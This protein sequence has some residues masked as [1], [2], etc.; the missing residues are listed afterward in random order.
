MWERIWLSLMSSQWK[1]GRLGCGGDIWLQV[2]VQ[3][4]CPEP[5]QLPW[6]VWKC[7]CRYDWEVPICLNTWADAFN[8][9]GYLGGDNVLSTQ[10]STLANVHLVILLLLFLK[11]F[12]IIWVIKVILKSYNS[13]TRKTTENL[14][15]GRHA[16]IVS[17]KTVLWKTWV[18]VKQ[19]KILCSFGRSWGHESWSESDGQLAELVLTIISIRKELENLDFSL[20]CHCTCSGTSWEVDG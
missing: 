12:W 2:E 9:Y 3:V 20:L 18:L 11:A 19:I 4:P 13:L 8:I 6:T 16:K 10:Y 14:F 7:S 17:S 5:A 15:G 1:R